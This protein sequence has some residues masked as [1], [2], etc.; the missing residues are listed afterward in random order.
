MVSCV[1]PHS[2][3]TE[4]SLFV[5]WSLREQGPVRGEDLFY[6]SKFGE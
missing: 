4:G 6:F 2:S 5:F 3:E 1:R